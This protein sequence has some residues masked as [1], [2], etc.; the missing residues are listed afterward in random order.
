MGIVG[1]ISLSD[2]SV[3]SKDVPLWWHTAGRTY[4]ASGYGGRIPTPHMV[5][6]N[7]RWRRVY[8]AVYS[9]NGTAYV[10]TGPRKP[11]IKPDWIVVES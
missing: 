6:L 7:G 2:P 3:E 11:G 1:R 10:E 5:R 4:T 8:C 9:N